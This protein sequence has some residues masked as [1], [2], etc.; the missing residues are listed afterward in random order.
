M[1]LQNSKNDSPQSEIFKN[2]DNY[3]TELEFS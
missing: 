1:T 2:K 3:Q